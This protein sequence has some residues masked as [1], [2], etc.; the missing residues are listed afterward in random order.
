MNKFCGIV[1]LQRIIIVKD[2]IRSIKS[3]IIYS[4]PIIFLTIF[5]GY[6]I[7]YFILTEKKTRP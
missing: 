1:A 5:I 2:T 4:C 6:L 7:I 3:I